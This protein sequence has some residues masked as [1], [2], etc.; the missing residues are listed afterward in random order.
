[1][2][3]PVWVDG[4]LKFR[5]DFKVLVLTFRALNGQAPKYLIDLVPRYEPERTLRSADQGLIKTTKTN[6]KTKGDR[7]FQAVAASLWN[8]LTQ[9]LRDAA[10][11]EIFKNKL[12]TLLFAQAF[13]DR[14]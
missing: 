11:V 6:L 2:Y 10:S 4:Q 5:V 9:F 14:T 8:A 1:M 13:V 12:K 3:F 7:A